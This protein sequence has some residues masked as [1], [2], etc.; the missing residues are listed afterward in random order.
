MAT[1]CSSVQYCHLK[2]GQLVLKK[3]WLV[4]H[5]DSPGKTNWKHLF[6]RHL[7]FMLLWLMTWH[8]L[9]AELHMNK[10]VMRWYEVLCHKRLKLIELCFFCAPAV[11]LVTGTRCL[12]YYLVKRHSQIANLWFSPVT[13]IV[14]ARK[15]VL[16]IQRVHRTPFQAGGL[17]VYWSI[18]FAVDLAQCVWHSCSLIFICLFVYSVKTWCLL[19]VQITCLKW[20]ERTQFFISLETIWLFYV[21]FP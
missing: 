19:F 18:C 15:Y 2:Y 9:S 20:T 13:V 5:R 1:S 10:K 4:F 8:V 12:D 21:Q 14:P 11:F 3:T 6:W 17:L 16:Q 7:I